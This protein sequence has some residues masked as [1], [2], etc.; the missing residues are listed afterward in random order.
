M[1]LERISPRV[2]VETGNLGSNNSLIVGSQGCILVDSPHRPSDAI[3]LAREVTAF[4]PL[5]FVVNTDHHPDHTIG[6]FWLPGEVVSHAGTRMRLL[7]DAPSDEYL[8]SLMARIDPE[9]LALMADYQVRIP[10][11]VFHNELTLHV[12]DVSLELTFQPGHTANSLL[13][14]CPQERV[15][16]SG[17]IF[18]EAGLPSFQDSRV[19]DW[20]SALEAVEAFDFEI[21]VPGHGDIADRSAIERYRSQGREVVQKVAAA[22]AAGHD[23]DQAMDEIRFE[24]RIHVDTDQYIGY[25]DDLIEMFQRRSVSR[26]YE[27]LVA[28]PMLIDR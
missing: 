17:D 13:A 28:N 14:Y 1:A 12:G 11:V 10:D 16:F 2:L 19:A 24:D 9:A 27:D 3:K 26:I 6:N 25:P 22:I 7:Q 23:C 8:H 18:C 21:L 20:F 4:G 15:L 5:R